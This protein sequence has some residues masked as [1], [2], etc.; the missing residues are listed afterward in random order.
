MTEESA[1]TAAAA[2]AVKG[3]EGEKENGKK[4]M[5]MAKVPLH[6]LFKYGD[7]TDVV[8]MLIGMVA[9]LGNG[10]SMVIMTIVFGQMVDAFGAT[11][12]DT[13]L[14]HVNKVQLALCKP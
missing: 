3:G 5:T 7:S 14:H 1:S 11:T 6:E 13:I 9:A 12:P 10:M 4:D 2:D 8:L